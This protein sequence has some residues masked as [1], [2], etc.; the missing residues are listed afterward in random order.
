MI[1]WGSRISSQFDSKEDF[2]GCG[3]PMTGETF[4][5]RDEVGIPN[6][7]ALGRPVLRFAVA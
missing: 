1:R 6:D 7:Q 5:Q 4:A 3:Q 2:K